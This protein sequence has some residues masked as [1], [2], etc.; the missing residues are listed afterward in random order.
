MLED[1]QGTIRPDFSGIRVI[2]HQ[3]PAKSHH[4]N[5]FLSANMYPFQWVD[6]DTNEEA[7]RLMESHQ[8]GLI[9][10]WLR[11]IKDT[12][13]YYW[14]QLK[15]LDEEALYPASNPVSATLR[16]S[17]ISNGAQK[18]QPYGNPPFTA[19]FPIHGS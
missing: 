19:Q 1:C 16:I 12:R 18:H 14:Q 6:F 10:N 4:I 8:Y 5:D 17:Q 15:D 9:D 3:Y 7:K 13:N 11:Q 2:G